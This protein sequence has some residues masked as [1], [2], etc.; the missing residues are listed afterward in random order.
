MK[1]FLAVI[2][3]LFGMYSYTYS[4]SS[5]FE[6]D[7]DVLL[8]LS[9]QGSFTN[10]SSGITLSFTDMATNLSS[11]RSQYY[12][13]EVSVLSTTRAIVQYTSVSNPGS[14]ASFVVDSKKN[15]LIDRG[16]NSI[17][18]SNSP[19]ANQ[20]VNGNNNTSQQNV[21]S[22]KISSTGKYSKIWD[23][24]NLNVSKFRNGDIIPEA[25]N[26]EEWVRAF[27]E[28]KPVWCYYDNNP[29]NGFKYGKLYNWFAVSD[30][31]GL[32]PQ[33]WR[34]PNNDEWN[35]YVDFLGGSD[36]AGEKIKSTK[37]WAGSS[38]G[39]NTSGF[40]ALP[41]GLRKEDGTFDGF[42]ENTLFWSSTEMDN[43]NSWMQSLGTLYDRIVNAY[44]CKGRGLS[45]RCIKG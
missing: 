7:T 2:A 37:E 24:K 1:K 22:S 31:R 34:I 16:N 17:Y 9:L 44:Y 45:V 23:T 30:P 3:I 42:G 14:S 19:L 33:G 21:Q 43:N 8:Y 28:G 11:G 18:T 38:S 39:T 5:L 6:S 12:S 29:D 40:N 10:A 15:I 27:K 13:P 35:E 32:A 36:A 4:Q 25:K 26:A 20:D 41:C